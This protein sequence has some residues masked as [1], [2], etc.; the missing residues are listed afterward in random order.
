M[1]ERIVDLVAKKYKRRFDKKFGKIQTE[2]IILSGG[3]FKNFKDVSNYISIIYNTINKDGFTKKDAEYLVYNYGKQTN[4]I[5]NLMASFS[6]GNSEEKL[7]KA[8]VKF[9]IENEMTCT[10]TDFFMR[11]TGRLF[12]DMNSVSLYKKIVINEFVNYF[13]W[14]TDTTEKHRQELEDKIALATTFN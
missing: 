4:T 2:K 14:N 5:L 9:T 8:E 10:P 3:D 7:I 11:R 6:N 13:N 1:S 12:F